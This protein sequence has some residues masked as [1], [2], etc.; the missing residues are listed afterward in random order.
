MSKKDRIKIRCEY[1]IDGYK[2]VRIFGSEKQARN[3]IKKQS[4]VH[5]AVYIPLHP[6]NH[7]EDEDE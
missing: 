5:E 4:G 2:Y 6:K 1:K 3:F 7:Q